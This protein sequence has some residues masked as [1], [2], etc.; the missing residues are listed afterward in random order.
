M[1]HD[2]FCVARC[3]AVGLGC[4]LIRETHA[5][6]VIPRRHEGRGLRLDRLDSLD[7]LNIVVVGSA[8]AWP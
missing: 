7:R 5:A 8:C 6:G 3:A 2:C 1:K 4:G